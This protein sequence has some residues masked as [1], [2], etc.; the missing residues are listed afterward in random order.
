MNKDKIH[1]SILWSKT[2]QFS[3]QGIRITRSFHILEKMLAIPT[4]NFNGSSIKELT[5]RINIDHHGDT[6]YTKN[7]KK[8]KNIQM[9]F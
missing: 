4:D 3:H 9:C 8:Q 1:K 6:K 5:S 2:H 7:A